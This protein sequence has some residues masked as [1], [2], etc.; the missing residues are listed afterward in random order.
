MERMRAMQYAGAACCGAR[1]F[2]RRLDRLRARVCEK[3]L[4]E[5]GRAFQK[6]LGENSREHRDVELHKIGELAVEHA[7]ERVAHRG[8]VASNREDAPTAQKIEIAVALAVPQVRPDAARETDVIADRLQN[9]HPH[10]VEMLR[11]Q[12]EAFAFPLG[13]ERGEII[14]RL[15]RA[16]ARV[17]RVRNVC[18]RERHVGHDR[19]LQI[20][21]KVDAFF[22]QR[23]LFA[24][25]RLRARRDFVKRSGK[26]RA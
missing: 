10:L 22:V 3:D 25:L 16:R 7:D 24:S 1:E 14:L 8:M 5:P 6:L 12:R 17:I 15:R 4:V 2:D 18:S 21:L 26:I 9:A 11:V 13:D 20:L 19:R 23:S